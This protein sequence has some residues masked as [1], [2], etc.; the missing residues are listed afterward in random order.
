MRTTAPS[1]P[2]HISRV[3]TAPARP[4][5]A[6]VAV[7]GWEEGEGSERGGEEE[8]VAVGGGGRELRV[9]TPPSLPPARTHDSHMPGCF[10]H[11][12]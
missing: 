7:G 6:V 11:L 5:S 3:R 2:S 10:F 8:E 9:Q 12:W 1:G 4:H